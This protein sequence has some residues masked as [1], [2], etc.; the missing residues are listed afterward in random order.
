MKRALALLLCLVLSGCDKKPAPEAEKGAAPPPIESSKPGAC[1]GGGG[2]VKDKVSAPLIPRSAGDYCLDPNGDVRAYGESAPAD[3][4][5]VCT[6]LFDGDCELY[7][8]FGLERVVTLRYV[9][10]KGSPGAVNMNL[11]RFATKDGAYAFFTKR[12]VADAD[13]V[14]AAPAKLAAG[15]AGAAG[16]TIAYVWRGEHV[17]ELSYTN[18]L[19]SPEEAKQSGD[20]ALL[21]VAKA[22]GEQL[23][24]DKD[25]PKAVQALPSESLVTLGVSFTTADALGVSGVGPGAVG[26]YKSGSKRWRVLSIV[27]GD[28]EAAKD[29]MKTLKKTPGA[30]AL[31][32]QSF[33][34]LLLERRADDT[35]P[36]ITWA[37]ARKGERVFAVGDEEHVLS[38]DQPAAEAA[39]VSLAETEKIE[40]LKKLVEPASK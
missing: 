16:N 6:E 8:S 39:K 3:L 34:T 32:G 5:K 7:K 4:G 25:P 22:I 28:E 30:K 31:K 17:V 12:V 23:P 29:V 15:G 24:G 40:H 27:R 33:D 26:F 9:D 19:E 13:P 14:E 38:G 37:V 20:K 36:K 18:E 11:S 35:S 1:S 21:P 2:T 10:G